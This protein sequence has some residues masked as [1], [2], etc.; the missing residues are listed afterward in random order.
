MKHFQRIL[1]I[2]LFILLSI[3]C[4]A[5]KANTGKDNNAKNDILSTKEMQ[6]GRVG[7]TNYNIANGGQVD[8]E[9]GWLFYSLDDGLYKCKEDGTEKT[10][11]F[12][13]EYGVYDI[14][15]IDEWVY[16][17]DLGIY[18]IKTDGTYY[19]QIAAED[20]RGGVHLVDGKIYNGSEYRMNFD[21]SGKERIYNNNVASGY[22]LNIV[23]GYIYFFDTESYTENEKIYK[24]KLDGSDPQAIYDGRTDYMIVDN[25]WIYFAD[26]DNK[27]LYKMKTDGTEKQLV[28]EAHVMCILENNGWIYYVSDGGIYKIKTDGTEKRLLSN[29]DGLPELQLHGDWLYYNLGDKLYSIKTDGTENHIFAQLGEKV[30]ENQVSNTNN[31][32]TYAKD[33]VLKHSYT[34]KF[35]K[36]NAV[37][38][39][40]FTISYPSNWMIS[41]NSVTSAGETIILTNER[42]VKI[43]YS[44]ICDVE[45]GNLGGGS[46]VL[47][48]RVEV[49]QVAESS[50]IPG[51]VQAA[52]Y[53]DLG[54]FAVA[55]LKLTGTLDMLND[56]DFTD[57]DGSVSF[58]V[59]PKSRLGIDDSVTTAYEGEFAFWYSG[60]ISLIAD[61]PDGKFTKQEEKEVILI[62]SSF[63]NENAN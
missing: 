56:T 58:A 38:Y 19:E 43:K 28:A 40:N 9:N 42:G 45:E 23:D 60:Y 21:G 54:E 5:C 10:K 53:R 29:I 48:K 61:A 51:Y 52:D 62:L 2:S 4:T 44:H 20:I 41:Q 32:T 30:I 13:S 34:T 25:G 22:T 15:V 49:S 35:S 47:M 26:Y 27:D 18:R 11:I 14:N 6:K 3:G 7:N 16:F 55:K 37:T 24:M 39:P 36:K 31:N 63:K 12:N 8:E 17:R 50:F 57:I 33:I 1:L 46:H 59:L